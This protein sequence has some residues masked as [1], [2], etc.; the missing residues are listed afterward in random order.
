MSKQKMRGPMGGGPMGGM[1][2][3]GEKAKDFKKTMKTL[4][5]YLKPYSLSII[6]GLF[7]HSRTVYSACFCGKS[8]FLIF[9]DNLLPVDPQVKLHYR[10]AEMRLIC[11]QVRAIL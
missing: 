6:I 9:V 1:G 5:K 10:Q 4:A 8:L 7:V 11:S 2:R 3:G